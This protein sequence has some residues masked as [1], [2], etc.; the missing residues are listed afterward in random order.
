MADPESISEMSNI[1][2]RKSMK[3]QQT[4]NENKNQLYEI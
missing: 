3:Y 1:L 4:K 2:P